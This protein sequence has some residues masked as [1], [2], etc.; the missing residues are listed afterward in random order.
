MK[1]TLIVIGAGIAGL[2]AGV[3]AARS[4]YRTILLEQ[5]DAP[6]GLCTS[7]RRKGYLFDG[8]AAGLA[9]S[10]PGTPIFR[11]WQDLGVIDH[12]PLHDPDNFGS[13]RLTDGRTITV[14]TDIA[15]LRDHLRDNFP[16]DAERIDEFVWGAC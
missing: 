4:G 8:S 16:R 9:G 12:C 15:H 2:S 1:K 10:A 11:L 13:I 5:A 7:W 6:G 3:Y 14:Y